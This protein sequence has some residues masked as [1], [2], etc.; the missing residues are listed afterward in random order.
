MDLLQAIWLGILQGL[1]EFLPISSS[2]H[3]ILMRYWFGWELGDPTTELMFDLALHVGTLVAIVMYFWRDLVRVGSSLFSSDPTRV[4]DRRLAWGILVGCIPAALV[5]ALFD[6]VIEEYFRSQYVLISSLLIGIGLL[7]ALVDRLGRKARSIESVGVID[8]F[9][10][11]VAQ[12][13]A[14]I[15][16]FSRSGITIIAGLMLGLQR[17]AAARFSFL[18]ATPITFGAAVWSFRKAFKQGIPPEMVVPMLAGGASALVVGWLCIAFLLRYLRTRS[19]MPFVVYRVFVGVA[20]LVRYFT[21][22]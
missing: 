19:L 2:A 15:P 3:L 7:M 12:A 22:G 20:T 4:V 16:G 5:G 11:G 1:T 18:L 9:L 13:F 14:L 6:D 8:A 21:G 17:E 10:I